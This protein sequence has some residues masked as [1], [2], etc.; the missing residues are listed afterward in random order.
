MSKTKSFKISKHAVLKAY[1][2][3]KSNKGAA[4]IDG[5]SLEKFEE[6]LKD[7]LYKIWNRMSSGTYFPPAEEHKGT[8]LLC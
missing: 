1:E 5:E 2:K 8:V 6:N 7:N 4:G 3:V